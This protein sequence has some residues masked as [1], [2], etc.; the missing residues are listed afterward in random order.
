MKITKIKLTTLTYVELLRG[1]AELKDKYNFT[2]TLKEARAYGQFSHKDLISIIYS[3]CKSEN[4]E[5]LPLV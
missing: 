3:I 1:Y 4:T 2:M 5:F